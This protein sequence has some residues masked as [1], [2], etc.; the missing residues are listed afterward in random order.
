MSVTRALLLRARDPRALVIA[1]ALIAGL[2]AAIG[3][4][5]HLA[6]VTRSLEEQARTPT[7]TAVVA[8]RDL[9]AGTR[10]TVDHLA[11]REVPEPWLS[12]EALLPGDLPAIEYSVLQHPV[13]AGEP[14]LWVHVAAPPERFSAQLS[15]GRRAVTI[16]VDDINSVSGMMQPGD[17]IDLYVTF[18][19]RGERV[20]A[21]L[22]QRMKVLATGQNTDDDAYAM[23]APGRFA[24]VTLNASP[25]EA[26]KLIAARQQ[27]TVSA[28][29]RHDTD[30]LPAENVA[31]GDLAR[32]LGLHEEPQEPER[33]RIPVLF[34]DRNPTTIPKLGEFELEAWSAQSSGQ[35][36]GSPILRQP[37]GWPSM[38]PP[39]DGLGTAATWPLASGVPSGPIE[40]PM[41]AE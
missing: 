16:P 9:P 33:R 1:I 35:P 11:A 32:L 21:P 24:T 8:A 38:P 19:V 15:A 26:V 41:G 28:M 36:P 12:A 14:L 5:Q 3:A 34:G 37:S 22:L 2:L 4:R 31:H 29:L 23:G 40:A 13:R 6:T 10:I 17:H 7:R 25:E 30:H 20:T 27:G 39:A 18:D